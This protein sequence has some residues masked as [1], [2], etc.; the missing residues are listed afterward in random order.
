MRMKTK[1]TQYHSLLFQG[2]IYF[3]ASEPAKLYWSLDTSQNFSLY[4]SLNTLQ[5][6]T[7]SKALSQ[8]LGDV[9]SR[10]KIMSLTASIHLE[11]KHIQ[12]DDKGSALSSSFK[13][14]QLPQI[15]VFFTLTSP[16]TGSSFPNP[17]HVFA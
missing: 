15:P 14:P 12:A 1:C 5:R 7:L 8:I 11:R 17:N 16:Q 6:I 9:N 4:H 13:G 10:K 2:T 3:C